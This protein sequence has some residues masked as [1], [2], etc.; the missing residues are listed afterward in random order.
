MKQIKL[1]ILRLPL[2]KFHGNKGSKCCFTDCI[3]KPFNVGMHSDVYESV[4]FKL[5][6]VIDTFVLC[7]L[8][9]LVDLDF[10]SRSQE[11]EKAKSTAPII[12]QS[13]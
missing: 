4:C 5:G 8:I 13:F 10:D 11:W 12:S 9:R 1:N 3:K 2:N 6:M 7:I